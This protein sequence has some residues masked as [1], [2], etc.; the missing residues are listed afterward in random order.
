LIVGGSIEFWLQ[1]G[2]LRPR[3]ALKLKTLFQE[4]P[5]SANGTISVLSRYAGLIGRFL[6]TKKG[7]VE[8]DRMPRY[9]ICHGRSGLISTVAEVYELGMAGAT[10]G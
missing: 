8:W 4:C 10:S 2:R 6:Q 9:L 3:A 5:F 7:L 1:Q